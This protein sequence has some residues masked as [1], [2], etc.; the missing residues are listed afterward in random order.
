MKQVRLPPNEAI[1][2]IRFA[3]ERQLF[4]AISTDEAIARAAERLRKRNEE[5]ANRRRLLAS[6]LRITDRI[7]PSL[8]E[9]VALVKRIRGGQ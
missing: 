1:G 5:E 9:R 3:S 8:M 4:D 6:A 7:I 2:R